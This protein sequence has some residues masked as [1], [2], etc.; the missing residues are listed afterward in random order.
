MGRI[1][2]KGKVSE[3]SLD[4]YEVPVPLLLDPGYF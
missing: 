4:R 2:V 3:V 1:Q